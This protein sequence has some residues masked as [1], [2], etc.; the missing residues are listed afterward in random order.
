M[1]LVPGKCLA[2]AGVALGNVLHPGL[3]ASCPGPGAECTEQSQQIGC[4]DFA[5]RVEIG[6]PC[7]VGL[8]LYENRKEEQKRQDCGGVFHGPA[9]IKN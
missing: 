2:I 7:A 5:I 9:A 3:R 6:L 1:S 4:A 8:C